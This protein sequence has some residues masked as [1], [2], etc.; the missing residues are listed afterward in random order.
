MNH[1]ATTSAVNAL[2]GTSIAAATRLDNA[3]VFLRLRPDVSFVNPPAAAEV[4]NDVESVLEQLSEAK[5]DLTV[6]VEGA[7]IR[8]SNLDKVLWPATEHSRAFTKRDL[9]IYYAKASDFMLPHL[10]DRPLS[11][12]RCPDGILGEQFF[13]KH[14][15]KGLP[16]YV[17]RVNIWSN[18][19]SKAGEYL[20]VNNLA[21]LMW[22]AQLAT[23]EIHPWYSRVNPE[24]DARD[25][26]TDTWTSEDALDASV[27]NFP[28]FL[29]ID[30]DPNIRSGKEK[31]GDEP[32]LNLEAFKMTI[33]VAHGFKEMLDDLGLVGYLKTSGKTGLHVYLPITRNLNYDIVRKLCETLGRLLLQKMPD[34]VTMEWVVSK[35]PEKIFFDHNQNSKGKTLASIYSPR[36]VPWAGVSVPL[37]W[38][39][40]REVYPAEFRCEKL[41]GVQMKTLAKTGLVD[42]VLRNSTHDRESWVARFGHIVENGRH[43]FVTTGIGTSKIPVRFGVPPQI[44]LLSID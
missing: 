44:D 43:L 31:A 42:A 12:V 41:D 10:K 19:N 35:R 28:D 6:T 30:L 11:F 17:D 36:P 38:D 37:R 29:V 39:E 14:W 33:D 22:L 23:L 34:K 20:L 26:P 16:D 27:L 32:E 5:K 40:L 4:K 7:E 8:Y 24:P 25:L 21:T 3:P 13:Q 15:E 18:H 9:A 2:G 1:Q